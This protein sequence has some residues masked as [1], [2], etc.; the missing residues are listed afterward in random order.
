MSDPFSP[1][2]IHEAISTVMSQSALPPGKKLA[3]IAMASPDGVKGILA[4]K[5][6]EH[7]T[8]TEEVEYHGDQF[9]AGASL[10]ASW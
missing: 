6:G 7:W 1:A 8:L 9:S 2:A 5:V 10:V 4:A 3:L